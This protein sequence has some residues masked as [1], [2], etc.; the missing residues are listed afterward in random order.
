MRTFHS[1]AGQ[2]LLPFTMP[3]SLAEDSAASHSTVTGVCVYI[4]IYMQLSYNLAIT[5]GQK[6][7]LSLLKTCFHC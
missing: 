2:Y 1:S 5:S 6:L 7:A 3:A 4:H